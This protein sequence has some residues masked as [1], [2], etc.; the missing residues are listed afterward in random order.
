MISLIVAH[1]DNKVI[2]KDNT[3]IWR[4][5]ADLVNF[6]NLTK[7]TTVI[8]GRKTYES[9]GKPL[10]NRLNIVISKTV[11]HID[12]VIVVSSMKKA[13]SKADRNK[14]IFIIG[15][16]QIYNL[17]IGY[18]KRLYITE[19]HTDIEGDAFFNLNIEDFKN[20]ESTKFNSDTENEYDYT[21]Q[22][23]ER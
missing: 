6:K 12:G 21:F 2:G 22:V 15:G 10:P 19:I 14:D 11:K 8:M 17:A 18:C 13:L 1:S 16:E 7:N 3:L 5:K 20:I 9:I 4:Q 23:Y